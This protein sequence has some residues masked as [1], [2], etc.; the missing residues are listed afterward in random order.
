MTE[1]GT[2]LVVTNN[3][4]LFNGETKLHG[5]CCLNELVTPLQ[6]TA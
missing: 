3:A 5:E 1:L 6:P 2:A 4:K